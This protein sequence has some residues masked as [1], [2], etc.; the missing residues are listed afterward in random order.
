VSGEFLR[1]E[2]R[3]QRRNLDIVAVLAGLVVFLNLVPNRI[4]AVGIDFGETRKHTF[5]VLL[6]LFNA[7]F[8]IVFAIYAAGDLSRLFMSLEQEGREAQILEEGE[9]PRYDLIRDLLRDA[10]HE[11]SD[12]QLNSLAAQINSQVRQLSGE[13]LRARAYEAARRIGYMR[14]AVDIF[15]PLLLGAG[16]AGLLIWKLI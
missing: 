10:E 2:T 3:K 1:D 11:D 4:S 6:L 14:V 15:V 5:L 16:A 13:R 7:W 12:D 9:Q 8:L